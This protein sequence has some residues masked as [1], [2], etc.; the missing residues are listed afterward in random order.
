MDFFLHL[1][2]IFCIPHKWISLPFFSFRK[3]S[4][5]RMPTLSSSLPFGG[6]RLEQSYF[7][8]KRR[9]LFEGIKIAT[10]LNITHL[11]FVDDILIFC[12]GSIR[13]VEK[14]SE[15]LHLFC[16]ATGMKLNEHKYSIATFN[17]EDD[18][19]SSILELFPF[20]ATS[21]DEGLKYPGFRIKP[22]C[23]KKEY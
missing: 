16:K 8:R 7:G 2:C 10:N 20:A 21:L 12:N 6:R 9:G 17:L 15:I 22:N 1:L 23:Y 11:L 14:L 13:D 18:I 5:T 4:P 3:G 19:I